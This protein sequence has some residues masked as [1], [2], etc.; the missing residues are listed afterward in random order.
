MSASAVASSGFDEEVA[1]SVSEGSTSVMAGTED[2]HSTAS[3]DLGGDDF[4]QTALSGIGASDATE[5]SVVAPMPSVLGIDSSGSKG[6]DDGGCDGSLP[7][8]AE[9][10]SLDRR[11]KALV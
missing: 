7:S 2:E 5:P 11:M 1:D 4:V 9:V 8:E 6:E 10:G 3:T